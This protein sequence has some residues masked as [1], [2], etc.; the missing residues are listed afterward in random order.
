MQEDVH[1]FF[2]FILTAR[3][4]QLNQDVSLT[5]TADVH[6]YVWAGVIAYNDN[7]IPT[8]SDWVILQRLTELSHPSVASSSTEWPNDQTHV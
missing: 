8:H 5:T 1:R 4:K 7:K 2:Y 3:V 6:V